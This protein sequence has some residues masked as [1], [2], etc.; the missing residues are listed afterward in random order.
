M[1]R[2][3]PLPEGRTP[4]TQTRENERDGQATGGARIDGAMAG[5]A[6]TTPVGVGTTGGGAGAACAGHGIRGTID[7]GSLASWHR[8]PSSCSKCPSSS[9]P[10]SWAAWCCQTCTHPERRQTIANHAMGWC[11]PLQG[12]CSTPDMPNIRLILAIRQEYRRER[13]TP[14]ARTPAPKRRA[15]CSRDRHQ[16]VSQSDLCGIRVRQE[17]QGFTSAA[18]TMPL[19]LETRPD[20]AGHRA[21]SGT[22][23]HSPKTLEQRATHWRSATV[24]GA[25]C[26]GFRVRRRSRIGR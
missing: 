19:T 17:A 9:S 7:H 21:P 18:S 8:S 5:R 14:L 4:D 1:A 20:A 22:R 13:P 25:F 24:T 3:T 16:L 11:L 6:S 10:S 15:R 26:D 12:N 2:A 23:R